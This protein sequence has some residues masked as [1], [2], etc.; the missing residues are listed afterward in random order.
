MKTIVAP[1]IISFSAWLLPFSMAHADDNSKIDWVGGLAI[2]YTS[3]EFDAKLDATPI[4][5]STIVN[6]AALYDDYFLMLSYGDSFGSNSVSEEED[7]GDSNRTD[8]DIT[9]GYR[10]NKSWNVYLGYK[11][12]ETDIEFRQRDTDIIRDEFY[13]KNG[14]FV[15]AAYRLHFE[16]SGTLSFS[17]GYIDLSTDNLFR[18]DEDGDT[19][20]EIEFDDLS[21]RQ[22]GSADGWSYGISWLI[23]VNDKMFFNTT[24]KVNDYEETI[25]ADG[26]NFSADQKLTYFNT[27]I[28][29]LF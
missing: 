27:G 1:A 28:L 14:W 29:Y 3:L 6:A 4:F 5:P 24:L 20:E 9:L 11:D 25:T 12:S 23:P 7:V 17:I 19:E 26:N 21:G 10:W 15:G 22:N 18:A 8:L 16:Q 2:G 13:R